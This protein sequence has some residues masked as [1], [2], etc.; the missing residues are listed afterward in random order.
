MYAIVVLDW[1]RSGEFLEECGIGVRNLLF[2]FGVRCVLGM[3]D[4]VGA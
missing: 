2:R 4:R 3:I 1:F